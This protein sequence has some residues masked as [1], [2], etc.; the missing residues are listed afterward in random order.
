MEDDSLNVH[1]VMKSLLSP[2]LLSLLLLSSS[3]SGAVAATRPTSIHPILARAERCLECRS[4]LF[5]FSL[6]G[7][8]YTPLEAASRDNLVD[9]VRILLEKGA[10]IESSRVLHYASYY[11]NKEVLDILLATR[12]D[13]V[14]SPDENGRTP[15]H[16]TVSNGHTNVAFQLLDKWG[17]NLYVKDVDNYNPIHFARIKAFWKLADQL[18]NYQS[19]HSSTSLK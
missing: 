6:F 12:P 17:A 15:L 2:L 9:V 16:W 14:N 13:L 3:S 5:G 18:E 1:S 11:G 4:L 19:K 10:E 7:L 8:G